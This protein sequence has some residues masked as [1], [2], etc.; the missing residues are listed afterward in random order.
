MKA[1]HVVIN[2]QQALPEKQ[3]SCRHCNVLFL[4]IVECVAGRL[5]LTES[6]LMTHVKLHLLTEDVYIKI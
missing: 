3:R 5:A 6:R 1:L 4:D 2:S